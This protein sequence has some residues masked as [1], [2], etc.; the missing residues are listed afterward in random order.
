MI[1]NYRKRCSLIVKR[2]IVLHDF[3]RFCIS[4]YIIELGG[5]AK[6]QWPAERVTTR[7]TLMSTRRRWFIH[8]RSSFIPRRLPR[9]PHFALRIV[10][11]SQIHAFSISLFQTFRSSPRSLTQPRRPSRRPHRPAPNRSRAFFNRS[12]LLDQLN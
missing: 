8:K 2:S 12:R 5:K 3:T 6:V 11:Y 7:L 4:V 9:R 10:I 1:G